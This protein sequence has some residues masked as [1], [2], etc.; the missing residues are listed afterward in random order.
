MPENDPLEFT[1]RERYIISYF[2]DRELSGSRRHLGYSGIFLLSSLACV[3][4][5]VAR[6]D[7]AFGFVGYGL[8][9]TRLCYLM[10]EGRR[11]NADFQNIFRK[12]DAKV[13]ELS[14]ARKK[15]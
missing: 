5:A 2:R 6:D 13:K 1:D 12:Y 11:W 4:Y 8:L 3:I 9:L 7:Q 15:Q 14:E 10:I